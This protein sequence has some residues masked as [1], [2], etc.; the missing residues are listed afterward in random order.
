MKTTQSAGQVSISFEYTRHIGPR[1]IHGGV[2]IL[3]DALK[4]YSFTSNVSWPTGENYDDDIRVSIEDAIRS[5]QGHIEFP[6]VV[7][8]KI[9]WNE[10]SSCRSGFIRAAR[11]ATLAAYDV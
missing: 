7:L 5:I 6:A 9:I 3:F 8:D 11:A 2:T 1:Y 4:N 10:F